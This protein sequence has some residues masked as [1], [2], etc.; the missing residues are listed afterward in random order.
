MV[1]M[2]QPR[3]TS[4]ALAQELGS[5]GGKVRSAKKSEAAKL[6]EQ[7]KK[8]KKDGL[9]NKT[10]DDIFNAMFDANKTDLDLYLL[11]MSI[12]GLSK[13]S[14]EKAIAF[15]RLIAWKESRFGK[16]KPEVL[17]QVNIQNNTNVVFTPEL[18]ERMLRFVESKRKVLPVVATVNNEEFETLKESR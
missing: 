15:D 7:L 1:K 3:I 8:L 16:V 6:R 2:I 4:T 18:E 17:N 9:T 5:K 14:R 13:T 10:A 11:C 12:K